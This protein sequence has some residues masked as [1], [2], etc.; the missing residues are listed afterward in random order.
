[1]NA[2]ACPTCGAQEPRRFTVSLAD[3]TGR[4]WPVLVEADSIPEAKARA[5][6]QAP[7]FIKNRR[8]TVSS[9]EEGI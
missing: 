5:L 4:L 8:F 2:A 3:D 1:M 7:R 9:V 6:N